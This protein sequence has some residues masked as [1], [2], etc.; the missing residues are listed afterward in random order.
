MKPIV[1]LT[2]PIDP[3]GVALLQ[4]RAEVRLAS[5]VDHATLRRE[6]APAAAIVVRAFLPADIFDQAL[7][8]IR[9]CRG[10]QG[11]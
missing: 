10:K 2:N 8:A 3:A 5:A 1:L 4:P 7:A 11:K 9:E 6:A